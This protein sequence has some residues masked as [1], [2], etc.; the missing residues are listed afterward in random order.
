MPLTCLRE[1]ETS[2]THNPVYCLTIRQQ[3]EGIKMLV[4][5]MLSKFF[6]R[7]NL[8]ITVLAPNYITMLSIQAEE[9]QQEGEEVNDLIHRHLVA[10]V[11]LNILVETGE[12]T[13][14]LVLIMTKGVAVQDR[15]LCVLVVKMLY[16]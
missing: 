8:F 16:S 9:E 7:I 12:A 11:V 2:T 3:L 15:P 4:T 5:N 10:S 1:L 14:V 13:T 6:E